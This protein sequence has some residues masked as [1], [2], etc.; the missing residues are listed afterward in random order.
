MM[1]EKQEMQQYKL[2]WK[3]LWEWWW[4]LELKVWPISGHTT[5]KPHNN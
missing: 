3:K 4:N 5:R 1:G 2:L